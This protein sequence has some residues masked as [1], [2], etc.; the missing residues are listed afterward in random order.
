MNTFA[1]SLFSLLFGWAKNLIRRVWTG[2]STGA[3]GGFFTWLGDHWMWVV[4]LLCIA[5]TLLDFTVWMIRWRPYL[6]WR[7]N[8]R[9][10][11][12]RLHLGNIENSR[13]FKRGYAGGIELD[14]LPPQETQPARWE[15]GDGAA[16]FDAYPPQPPEP[17]YQQPAALAPSMGPVGETPVY[18]QDEAVFQENESRQRQFTPAQSYEAPPMFPSTRYNAAFATDLPAA[19]RK[20]RSDKYE[21]KKPVWAD[22]L[23]GGDEEDGLLDGLPPAVDRQQA[24]HEPVYPVKPQPSAPYAAWQRPENGQTGGSMR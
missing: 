17:V 19:R 23:I 5:G 8:I 14:M 1:N 12:R 7:T 21:R 22:K 13:N 16:A 20:R 2:A 10:L 18:A 9:K 15:E 6:V 24:F 4:L 11:K 3:Y